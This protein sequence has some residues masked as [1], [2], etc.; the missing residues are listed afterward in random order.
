MNFKNMTLIVSISLSSLFTASLV[1]MQ[2]PGH[3]QDIRRRGPNS[4]PTAEGAAPQA[5]P[6]PAPAHAG[7]RI[8]KGKFI[9]PTVIGL[10]LLRIFFDRIERLIKNGYFKNLFNRY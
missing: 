4:R 9:Y 2:S 10:L 7:S 8:C 1:A 5:D 6:V 3:G